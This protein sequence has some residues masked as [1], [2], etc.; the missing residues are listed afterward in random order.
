MHVTVCPR[1]WVERAPGHGN[2]SLHVFCSSWMLLWSRAGDGQVQGWGKEG[3]GNFYAGF[4]TA[5]GLGNSK[6]VLRNESR[7]S[8]VPALLGEAVPGEGSEVEPPCVRQRYRNEGEKTRFAQEPRDLA[9][10]LNLP[11]PG[12]TSVGNSNCVLFTPDLINLKS[13]AEQYLVLLW[14]VPVVCCGN[15]CL[16]PGRRSRHHLRGASL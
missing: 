9:K 16:P 8:C 7:L 5:A 3:S 15:C 6:L 12:I 10:D 13:G 2:H 14:F 1:C 4:S 11:S